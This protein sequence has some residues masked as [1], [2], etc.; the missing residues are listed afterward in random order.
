MTPAA[1]CASRSAASCF[2][3]ECCVVCCDLHQVV[4][5]I[6]VKSGAICVCVCLSRWLD[7]EAAP[8]PA[9]RLKRRHIFL[10]FI[11]KT[12]KLKRLTIFLF[13]ASVWTQQPQ[14]PQLNLSDF[15]N[16]FWSFCDCGPPGI[17]SQFISFVFPVGPA[18]KNWLSSMWRAHLMSL[19]AKQ[20]KPEENP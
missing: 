3:H 20:N 17:T 6:R 10:F 7:G 9:T 13:A 5:H 19:L 11:W 2:T 15:K 4:V 18:D 8:P 1:G 14:M 12:N 16:I